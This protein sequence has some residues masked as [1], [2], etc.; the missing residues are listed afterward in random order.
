MLPAQAKI[1]VHSG[2]GDCICAVNH[3]SLTLP[4][5][6]MIEFPGEGCILKS[7]YEWLFVYLVSVVS[8]EASII[9][10]AEA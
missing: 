10:G 1:I 9:I 4:T 8:A 7:Q 6:Y 5:A 3:R 2:K